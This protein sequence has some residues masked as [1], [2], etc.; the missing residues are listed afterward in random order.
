MAVNAVAPGPVN[1]GAVPPALLKKLV[2][3]TPFKRM[4]AVEEIA[5]SVI[6]LIENDYVSGEILDVNAARYLD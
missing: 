3:K 5:H 4:A 6:F 2:A 1:T